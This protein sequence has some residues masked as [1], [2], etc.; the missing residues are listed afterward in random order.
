M[1]NITFEECM[2]ET[3]NETFKQRTFKTRHPKDALVNSSIIKELGVQEY[4][5]RVVNQLLDFVYKYVTSMLDD[6]KIYSN[7]ANKKNIDIEDV[8]LAV[9][10]RVEKDFTTPPPREVL[11]DIART[12]NALP[13]SLVKAH[14]GL[15]LPADR[16]CLTACNYKLKPIKRSVIAPS[17]GQPVAI[18][19]LPLTQTPLQSRPTVG[20]TLRT[21]SGVVIK[22]PGPSK[23]TTQTIGFSV[24]P[25]NIPRAV[26]NLG[27]STGQ[28]Q[29]MD[30][31]EL[32]IANEECV[33]DA[34]GIKRERED[35]HFDV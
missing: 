32:S 28:T 22:P 24:Q 16:Y 29:T 3:R 33:T 13:L 8:R 14:C 1:G 18:K 21:P 20:T 31:A 2:L 34:R 26:V 5:P 11:M 7:H 6:S 12:K 10:L 35:M 23:M 9:A 15:R 4:D 27:S 25:Q 19:S 17:L 30:L